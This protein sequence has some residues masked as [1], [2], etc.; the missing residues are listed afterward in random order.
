MTESGRF[1]SRTRG[2][3]RSRATA[4]IVALVV[5]AASPGGV[6]SVMAQ[7]P[8][9]TP[10]TTDA[11]ADVLPAQRAAVAAATQD[12]VSRYTLDVT[13]DPATGTIGG[14][15]DLEFVNRYGVPLDEIVFRLFPNADHYGPGGTT[16]GPVSVDG[17]PATP[18]LSVEDTVLDIP[19]ARP[20]APGAGVA[21]AMTFTT[22]V[23]V[24]SGGSYGIL[25]RS[26]ATGA[27]ALADW[28]PSLAGYETGT[29][30]RR[31]PPFD[32]VD[33]TFGDV[34]LYDLTLRAP[35]ET[36]VS[37]GTVVARSAGPAGETVT[38][39]VA[40][41]VRDLTL[42]F[43]SN[44]TLA[45]REVGETTV[46]YATELDEPV[47]VARV[48]DVVARSLAA[49]SDRFGPY[50]YRELDLVDVPLTSGTLGISWSGLVFLDGP[51][52]ATSAGDPQYYD[53]LLA[54]EIAHQ[55]WGNLIGGN[56][57]DHTFITEGL[58]NYTM[59]M[60]VEWT[61]GR[62]AAVAMLRDYV[63]PRYLT[64]LRGAGDEVADQPF[65]GAPAGFGDIVY[66]KAA[67]GF[68]AIRLAI[69]DDA[70][71]A[72]LRQFAGDP[73]ATAPGFRFQ[74]AEPSD[75]LAAFASAAD[76]PTAVADLWTHWF[77][78]S[79]TTSDE[80]EQV[81]AG[82]A[83][84]PEVLTPP[85]RAALHHD[86]VLDRIQDADVRDDVEGT[87]PADLEVELD[88]APAA[89]VDVWCHVA[90][91]DHRRATKAADPVERAGDGF[92][93]K[94]LAGRD[95]NHRLL[96]DDSAP[97]EVQPATRLVGPVDPDRSR[98]R[99][100]SRSLCPFR[101]ARGMGPPRLSDP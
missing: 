12:D 75:L 79:T 89:G 15:L 69:G 86:A 85:V 29:G 78:Q 16:V 58:T 100:L 6:P 31:D 60:E 76:D 71:F 66:G 8:V 67:L 41:P 80:V 4:F 7:T 50:P 51:S 64:L 19:L 20:V 84:G 87:V 83:V 70:F 1:S 21:V 59:T 45:T 96:V 99:I 73:T 62:P 27:W 30:W 82:Y 53:F 92:L 40:G 93:H 44:W 95:M 88:A 25:S 36:V 97:V 56:S 13:V 91:A 34:A 48:L 24:D 33:P 11:W 57:N 74:V 47:A 90:D 3:L 39:I 101:P 63:A 61:Q 77:E 35:D 54:H 81:I 32:N 42:A 5:L 68:L 49:Y 2:H 9:A 37:S 26:S 55:W 46:T 23:P 52:L 72:A 28:Y 14:S 10:A 22:T 43:G 38:R 65:P 98:H 18:A 94:P 17:A